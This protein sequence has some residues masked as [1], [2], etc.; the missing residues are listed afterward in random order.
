MK[1]F[2]TF[3]CLLLSCALCRS[4]QPQTAAEPKRPDVSALPE[5]FTSKLIHSEAAEGLIHET[6][7]FKDAERTVMLRSVWWTPDRTKIVRSG[8]I[9]SVSGTEALNIIDI[10]E[11]FELHSTDVLTL[12]EGIRLTISEAD[13]VSPKQWLFH[14]GHRKILACFT[15]DPDGLIRPMTKSEYEIMLDERIKKQSTK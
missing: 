12:P 6:I 8:H 5:W 4:Q 7:L 14:D 13:A 9:V 11:D 15:R 10:R 3:L 1:P 2:L